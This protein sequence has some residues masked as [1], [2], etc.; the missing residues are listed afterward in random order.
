MFDEQ[1]QKCINGI[2]KASLFEWNFVLFKFLQ[3]KNIL[4]LHC[5]HAYFRREWA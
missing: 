3:I 2:F 1:Q 5:K 4:A